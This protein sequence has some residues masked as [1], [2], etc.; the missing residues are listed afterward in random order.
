MESVHTGKS[1]A[2]ILGLDPADFELEVV[3]LVR[4]D[5]APGEPQP[6]LKKDGRLKGQVRRVRRNI[7][8]DEEVVAFLETLKASNQTAPKEGGYSGF[9]ERLV[10]QSPEF[11]VYRKR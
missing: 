10:R 11:Q 6:G 9:L 3:D 2:E 7:S 1:L 4:D 8:L 5:V